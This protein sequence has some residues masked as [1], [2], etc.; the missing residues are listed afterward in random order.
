M[1]RSNYA[2]DKWN[3]LATYG[4]LFFGVPSHGMNTT[5][6]ASMIEN[7]PARF[8][9]SLLDQNVG[10]RLREQQHHEFCEAFHFRD[11]KVVQFYELQWSPTV[12]K[13]RLLL[14]QII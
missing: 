10:Y 8:T 5:A 3:L 2:D 7:L 13:V 11:S 1:R 4:A 6:M 12:S 14:S 9:L